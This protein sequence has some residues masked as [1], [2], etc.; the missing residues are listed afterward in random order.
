MIMTPVHSELWNCLVTSV[1]KRSQ[2]ED[3]CH[4]CSYYTEL[5]SEKERDPPTGLNSLLGLL[6]K[7]IFYG[8]YHGE[9]P[10]HQNFWIIVFPL[11]SIQGVFG[12]LTHLLLRG[13][14]EH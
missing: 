12:C 1:N 5:Y 7:M 2:D 8:L 3:M 10:L 14:L 4:T 11:C 9:P 6:F 13:Y